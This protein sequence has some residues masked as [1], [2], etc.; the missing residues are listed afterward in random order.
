MKK[1]M[2]FDALITDMPAFPENP[3][4]IVP[5]AHAKKA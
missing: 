1:L 2:K 4:I 3:Y 5:G